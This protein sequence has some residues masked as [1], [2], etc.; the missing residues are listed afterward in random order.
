MLRHIGF[1][2]GETDP[3]CWVLTESQLKLYRIVDGSCDGTSAYKVLNVDRICSMTLEKV[4]KHLFSLQVHD[5]QSE[6]E[7]IGNKTL[8]SSWK[9]Q[10]TVNQRQEH[11]NHKRE[12]EVGIV[13]SMMIELKALTLPVRGKATIT[14]SSPTQTV[15]TSATTMSGM[16]GEG[17]MGYHASIEEAFILFEVFIS[18]HHSNE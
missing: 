2:R 3:V 17:S 12:D 7:L 14:L 11:N 6:V 10:I 8:L 4:E 1:V 9:D 13:Q 16:M 5:S 18:K 15:T